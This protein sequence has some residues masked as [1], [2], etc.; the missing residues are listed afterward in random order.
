MRRLSNIIPRGLRLAAIILT[1]LTGSL[2]A[3]AQVDTIPP[4]SP[5]LS[6]VSVVSGTGLVNMQW[7]RSPDADVAG[8]IIYQGKNDIW[9]AIDT[10]YN[11]LADTYLDTRAHADRFPVSYVIAAVDTAGNPSPL[12]REHTTN[13]LTVNFDPCFQRITL[14]WTGYKGWEGHLTSYAVY[15]REGNG[16][17]ALLDSLSPDILADT[18]TEV[19]PNE[20]YCFIIRAWHDSGW[21]ST[22]NRQC[23]SAVMLPPPEY[24]SVEEASVTPENNIF[25]RFLTDNTSLLRHYVLLRGSSP[26]EISDTV[27]SWE[28][29]T[30]AELTYTDIPED[31]LTTPL[32]YVL[33][34]MNDCG[35]VVKRSLPATVMVLQGYHQDFN[36]HLAWNP[37]L[38]YD[39][40]EKYTVYR[41][42]GSNPEEPVG[43]L[44]PTDTSWTENIESLQYLPGN[45][46]IYCYRIEAAGRN[47]H[48]A[49]EEKSISARAC[50]TAG[51]QVYIPNAFTPNGD[52]QNDLWAPVFSFAPD[53]YH[54]IIRDRWGTIVFESHD[55]LQSW[56]GTDRKGKPVIR[57]VYNFYMEAETPQG[58]TIRRKGYVTVIFPK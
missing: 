50:I 52:G 12:T 49:T 11:P 25:L 39:T 22:S 24:I 5:V 34:V 29:F 46:G 44:S 42:T 27:M 36:V 13:Y 47:R 16:T 38:S 4:V 2:Q 23:I 40:L 21:V 55:Y 41:Q 37:N 32:Y 45:N 14:S 33:A 6:L 53:K 18:L 19:L 10:V 43:T 28:D 8:Y 7:E 20:N 54:L 51:Q 15:G 1:L 9:L 56:D 17:Y 30:D 58:E 31:S 35:R 57:G 26:G 48:G 3:G